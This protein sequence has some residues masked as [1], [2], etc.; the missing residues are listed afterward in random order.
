VVLPVHDTRPEFLRDAIESVRGQSESQ[1]ELVI[2]LDAATPACGSVASEMAERDAARIAVIGETGGQPRG[3]SAAR[4]LGVA[5]TRAPMIGF[6]DAD[7]VFEPQA[8]AERR[9]LLEANPDVAMV[10]GPTLYWHSWTGDPADQGR[11]HMPGL[12]V[13]AGAV[14]APPAIVSRFIE[15]TAAVPCPCSILVRRWAIDAIGGFDETFPG[16]YDDQAFY[17]RLGLCFPL[18]P[19]GQ[20]LDRYRQHPESMTARASRERGDEARRRFLDWLEAEM[21][22]TGVI[23]AVLNET[24]ARERWKLQHPHLARIFRIARRAARR[25]VPGVMSR[26]LVPRA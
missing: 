6:L 16:L 5:H 23:D 13:E 15:G 10:Y 7:D 18:L 25:L 12:G 19:T 2:V 22:A 26:R 24:I 21:A 20:R 9:S 4:N 8:L 1:W 3:S 14:Q 11:D 17:A